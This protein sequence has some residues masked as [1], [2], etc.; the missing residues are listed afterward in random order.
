MQS[1]SSAKELTIGDVNGSF[2]PIYNVTLR[3]IKQETEIIEC[4][5]NFAVSKDVY[6]TI[7]ANKLFNLEPEIKHTTSEDNFLPQ[8]NIKLEVSLK[9]DLLPTL[10]E[11]CDSEE[12]AIN[13]LVSLNQERLS[14]TSQDESE[15]AIKADNNINDLVNAL[16]REESWLCLSVKQIQETKEVGFKTFWSYINFSNLNSDDAKEEEIAEGVVNFIKDYAETNLL[17]I[18]ETAT[19]D[20]INSVSNAFEEILEESFSELETD[21][22]SDDSLF[23]EVVE[24]FESEGWSFVTLKDKS[25]LRLQHRGQ[26][27]QWKC[28]A[29]VREKQREFIFYSVCPL[30]VSEP[31][32]LAVAELITKINYGLTVGNFDLSLATGMIRYKT[33]INVTGDYLSYEII[34]NLVQTNI[35]MMDKFLPDILT[36]I[37]S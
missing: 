22:D 4:R 26:N 25:G 35:A 10:L 15:E 36:V 37:D 17:E 16:L 7:I 8:Y 20:I 9:P 31:K 12:K 2:F 34:N 1:A 21:F 3:Y 30:T 33:S 28:L 13:Y 14:N 19:K 29:I 11:H 6:K 5:L 18:A 32:K 23:E 24:F 27:G